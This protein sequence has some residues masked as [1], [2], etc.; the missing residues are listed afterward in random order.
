MSQP[1]RLRLLCGYTSPGEAHAHCAR[2][3]QAIGAHGSIRLEVQPEVLTMPQ[4]ELYGIYAVLTD[5]ARDY[6]SPQMSEEEQ[7]RNCTLHALCNPIVWGHVV[8]VD[9]LPREERP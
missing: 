6:R 3:A 4:L 1:A 5:L 2:I 8:R 9:P 7:L